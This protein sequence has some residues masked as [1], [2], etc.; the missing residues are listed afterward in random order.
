MK[1]RVVEARLA[2]FLDRADADD[3]A[4]VPLAP[5]VVRMLLLAFTSAMTEESIS[6]LL[7]PFS[8]LK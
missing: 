6:F 3:D 2:N 8:L 4:V 1:E 5:G 7:S